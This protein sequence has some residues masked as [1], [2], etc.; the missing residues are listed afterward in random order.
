MQQSL[1]TR[2]GVRSVNVALGPL[3]H[4]GTGVHAAGDGDYEPTLTA[5]NQVGKAINEAQRT[6]CMS[7]GAL[8]AAMLPAASGWREDRKIGVPAREAIEADLA[9]P[10]GCKLTAQVLGGGL[11]ASPIPTR[12]PDL[13]AGMRL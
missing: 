2:W 10:Y 1:W 9:I 13:S 7:H 3:I 6:L 5:H 4:V 11:K 8:H 12:A